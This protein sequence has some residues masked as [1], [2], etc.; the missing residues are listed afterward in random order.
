MV[1]QLEAM[2]REVLARADPERVG[3]PPQTHADEIKKY[4][5]ESPRSSASAASTTS[6]S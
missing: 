4:Y 6:R 3:E 5:D 2:R 1:Q